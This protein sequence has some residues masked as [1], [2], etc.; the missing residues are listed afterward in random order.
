MDGQ[1]NRLVYCDNIRLSPPPPPP[2]TRVLGFLVV[3]RLFNPVRLE[4]DI[5]ALRACRTA[6]DALQVSRPMELMQL[7]F[8]PPPPPP[9]PERV[10]MGACQSVGKRRKSAV[11]AASHSL[12]CWQASNHSD[13]VRSSSL[14]SG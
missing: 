4:G 14:G 10:L 5:L 6:A 7:K 9:K 3:G 11:G 12:G 8:A 13:H 2:R 1:Y